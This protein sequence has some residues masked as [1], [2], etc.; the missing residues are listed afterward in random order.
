MK[1]IVDNQLP[2][3]LARLILT[4]LGSEA[5]HVADVGLRD[6][7][8]SQLWE[9]A[10]ANDAVLISKDEDFVAMYIAR[11]TAR[12]V[13]VRIGNCR[14]GFLLEAFRLAWPRICA[15]LANREGFVEVR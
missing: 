2:P 12:L 3:A 13:W 6:A 4:E 10:S 9:Y 1:F 11:P 5:I 8:D 14:R 7:S 15:R